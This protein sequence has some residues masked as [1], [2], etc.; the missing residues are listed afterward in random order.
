MNL[1]KKQLK[2]YL[3]ARYPEARRSNPMGGW[4]VADPVRWISDEDLRREAEAE[5]WMHTEGLA[6][7]PAWLGN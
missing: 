6:E 5:V 1:T 3:D 7:K 2:A 4:H